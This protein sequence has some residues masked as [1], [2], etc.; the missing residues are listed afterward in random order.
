[1]L[2]RTRA[3]QAAQYVLSWKRMAFIPKK[4]PSFEEIVRGCNGRRGVYAAVVGV[5]PLNKVGTVRKFLRSKLCGMGWQTA[6]RGWRGEVGD[7]EQE[8]L[9][10]K[11][12]FFSRRSKPPA[13]RYACAGNETVL[14]LCFLYHATE[15]IVC[16]VVAKPPWS[17][18]AEKRS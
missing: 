12:C 11:T 1:M 17:I 2:A 15:G 5:V 6:G 14:G 4:R 3:V 13:S 8:V 18:P 9:K 7:D 16:L 10:F